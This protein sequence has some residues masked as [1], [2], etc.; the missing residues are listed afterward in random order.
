[1][2]E[3]HL[4][5]S[6]RSVKVLEPSNSVYVYILYPN[7]E[8]TTESA[9]AIVTYCMG[10]YSE[11]RDVANLVL[12][13]PGCKDEILQEGY[14]VFKKR[15][16]RRLHLQEVYS[17]NSRA[18]LEN[19]PNNKQ[20][21]SKHNRSWVLV[22][23]DE[24]NSSIAIYGLICAKH[25]ENYRAWKSF[26]IL[27]EIGGG[28]KVPKPAIEDLKQFGWKESFAV[29]EMEGMAVPDA[30]DSSSALVLKIEKFRS[31]GL[32]VTT[33]TR[34]LVSGGPQMTPLTPTKRHRDEQFVVNSD[35]GYT[36]PVT[37]YS[38]KIKK[39]RS[40]KSVFVPKGDACPGRLWPQQQQLQQLFEPRP[41][42][43]QLEMKPSSDKTKYRVLSKYPLEE[44]SE[45]SSPNGI[46]SDQSQLDRVLEWIEKKKEK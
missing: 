37:Q 39:V 11:L 9:T 22:K 36:S 15:Q 3:I 24:E 31:I 7:Q 14:V 27:A 28:F 26:D 16:K 1:M 46:F 10:Q 42:P 43:S 6:Y 45:G 23:V 12:R 35:E 30:K 4:E 32:P 34:K 19:Q 38:S 40:A 33:G 18:E 20:K 2:G 29:T 41:V 21:R 5:I 13:E 17:K 8:A 44:G 25:L